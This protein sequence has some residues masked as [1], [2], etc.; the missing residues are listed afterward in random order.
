MKSI[1]LIA[2]VPHSNRVK[3]P[4]NLLTVGACAKKGDCNV[5]GHYNSEYLED[6]SLWGAAIP[7]D[8]RSSCASELGEMWEGEPQER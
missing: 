7:V 5:S 4:K 2:I 3:N 6:G 1:E 8:Q